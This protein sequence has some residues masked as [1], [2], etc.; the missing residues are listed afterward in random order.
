MIETTKFDPIVKAT[1][2]IEQY[3]MLQTMKA[4]TDAKMKAIKADLE[5]FAT[6]HKAEFTDGVYDFECCGYLRYGRRSFV[7]LSRGKFDM[8][9]VV[10]LF[11]EFLKKEFSISA[12]KASFL[13]LK[14]VKKAKE[15]GLTLMSF[16]EFEIVRKDKATDLRESKK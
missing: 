6:D 12:I 14:N 13:E 11:P 4:D 9:R 2:D 8:L 16:E 5:E 7:K 15:L 1:M 3:F 10:K